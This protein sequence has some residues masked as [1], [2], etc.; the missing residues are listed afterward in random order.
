MKMCVPVTK[1]QYDEI[2]DAIDEYEGQPGYEDVSID[3]EANYIMISLIS[4]VL[5]F[6]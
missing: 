1:D 3:C 4:L 2:D 5:L 6:L